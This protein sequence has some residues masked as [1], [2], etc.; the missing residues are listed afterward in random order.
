MVQSLKFEKP[1]MIEQPPRIT[2]KTGNV[3]SSVAGACLVTSGLLLHIC[4]AAML[5]SKP[6]AKPVFEAELGEKPEA[7]NSTEIQL[8]STKGIALLP[9]T[10]IK[11][12]CHFDLNN[13]TPSADVV[14]E[15][16]R[17]KE[18]Q[19]LRDRPG[20]LPVIPTKTVV[21]QKSDNTFW[22]HTTIVFSSIHNILYM[23]NSFLF[24]FGIG[25]IFTHLL[26]YA[27]SLGKSVKFGNSMMSILGAVSIFGRIALNALCQQKWIS[28]I[29]LYIVAVALCG[30]NTANKNFLPTSVYSV[31]Q[32]NGRN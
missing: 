10:R 18:I 29:I 25:V 13:S 28:S 22:H 8:S 14:H 31:F 24:F 26:A 12:D 9:T 30:K 21:F 2:E 11:N 15:Q 7:K 1:E 5:I 17:R 23:L 4:V 32:E 20:T 3:V 6:P 16:G 19:G 27:A